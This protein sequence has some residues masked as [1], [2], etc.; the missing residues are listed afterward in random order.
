MLTT[1]QIGCLERFSKLLVNQEKARVIIEPQQRSAGFWFG[2]GNMVEVAGALYLTGRYRNFGDSR[3][4]LGQGERG[5]EAA[6]FR[7]S[8]R[9]ESWE[10]IVSFAK[11][12]LDVGNMR[13]LSIEGTA[14]HETANGVELFVSTEKLGR[15]YAEG[16]ESFQKEGTGIWSIDRIAAPSVEELQSSGI[17]EVLSCDDPQYVHVKDPFVYDSRSGATVLGF[18]THPFNWASSNTG[19]MV[20]FAATEEWS[21]PIYDHFTRGTTWD[22]GMS[23]A[24][25]AID[26]P[27]AG[28]FADTPKATLLFYDGGESVRNLDEHKEA[29][30]RPRGYSCE[31]LGGAAYF[32]DENF[33]DIQ[34]LSRYLPFF[35]SPMGAGTSRYVDVLRTNEGF[36][37]TWQ[38]SQT[39]YS[40]PLVMN[41]VTRSEAEEVLG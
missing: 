3:T 2:G 14:L 1:E 21:A 7:S 5:L 34:R 25:A 17:E 16:L 41:Y 9:G 36:Y 37:A 18:C 31:E 19:Y 6:I 30:S 13:V 27:A 38:Q 8:D 24:T 20:R 33:G 23:R 10:K 4:G 26:V 22:A 15:R 35:V 12:D 11:T 28:V 40:Q 32:S 39:D 29:V